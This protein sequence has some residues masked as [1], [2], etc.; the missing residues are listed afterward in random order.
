MAAK[1]WC[2]MNKDK[3]RCPECNEIFPVDVNSNS[4]YIYCSH[5]GCR[6]YNEPE[7]LARLLEYYCSMYDTSAIQYDINIENTKYFLSRFSHLSGKCAALQAAFDTLANHILGD[8]YHITDP[9]GGIQA[10]EIKTRDMLDALNKRRNRPLITRYKE[11]E[12]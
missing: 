7:V 8:D 3:A 1:F 5:C 6:I 11:N 12:K 2:E 10:I 9:V 4:V